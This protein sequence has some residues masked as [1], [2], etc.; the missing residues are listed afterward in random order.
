MFNQTRA[1]LHAKLDDYLSNYIKN[2]ENLK[3]RIKKFKQFDTNNNNIID[4][5][6]NNL[7]KEMKVLVK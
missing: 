5:N 2:Y 6:D 1:E 3:N 4:S 7:M